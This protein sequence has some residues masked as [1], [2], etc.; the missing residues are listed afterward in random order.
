MVETED[1]EVITFYGSKAVDDK[2]A[3]IMF[4]YDVE[5]QTAMLTYTED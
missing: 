3:N 5:E 2:T 1:S 4:T